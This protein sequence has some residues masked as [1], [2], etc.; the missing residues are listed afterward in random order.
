MGINRHAIILACS[1]RQRAHA[2]SAMPDTR[3]REHAD[4]D[5]ADPA[6]N[7]SGVPWSTLYYTGNYPR[8]QRI[9]KRCD[10]LNLFRRA[11]SVEPA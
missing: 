9:K 7:T 8:L 11:L 2:P 10:P 5:L 3:S 6:V 4:K 1:T